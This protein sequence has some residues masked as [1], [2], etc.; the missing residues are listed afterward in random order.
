M[1]CTAQAL[2]MILDKWGGINHDEFH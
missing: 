2:N 1:G